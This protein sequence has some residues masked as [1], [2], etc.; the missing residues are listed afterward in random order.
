MSVNISKDMD[1]SYVV[2]FM[3]YGL[4]FQIDSF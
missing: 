4:T 1:K 3:T 2:H